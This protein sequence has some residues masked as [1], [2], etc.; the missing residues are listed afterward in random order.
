MKKHDFRIL[1]ENEGE[2]FY[3]LRVGK[4]FLNTTLEAQ[5]LS[6]KTKTFDCI[7]IFLQKNPFVHES[8]HKV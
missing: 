8:H 1:E 2:C 7:K 3:D 4:D 5:I 6:E